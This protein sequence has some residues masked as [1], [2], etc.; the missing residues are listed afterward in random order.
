MDTD[1]I[2]LSQIKNLK[3]KEQLTLIFTN[4]PEKDNITNIYNVLVNQEVKK[5]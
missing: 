4:Q 1:G 3:S 2:V 5:K